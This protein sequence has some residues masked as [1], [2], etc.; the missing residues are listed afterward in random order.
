MFAL[1]S[2]PRISVQKGHKESLPPYVDIHTHADETV[3]DKCDT[4]SDDQTIRL[5]SYRLGVD[6]VCH[7]RPFS[8]GY[9]PWDCTSVEYDSNM[10]MHHVG[11]RNCMAI[12]EIGLDTSRA[13][14]ADESSAQTA[15]FEQQLLL[16]VKTGKPVIIHS[17]H[18]LDECLRIMQPLQITNVLF[19]G[20]I[21]NPQQAARVTARGYYL[22]F[23]LR[24]LSSQRTVEALKSI[25][26][27]RLFLETDVH[28]RDKSIEE[29]YAQVAALLNID[30][31]ELRTI[32]YDNYK[33]F[34]NIQK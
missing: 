2:K 6:Q 8:A 27:S 34:F 15:L 12:G 10:I 13:A 7:S 29:I 11:H 21:G 19:H 18:A 31:S 1:L 14:N 20:F 25:P 22:G 4:N 26:V 32:I 30:S 16:A 9:H 5:I 24:S 33:R 17:V 23:G 28:A 3:C